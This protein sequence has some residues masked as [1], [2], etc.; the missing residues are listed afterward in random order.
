MSDWLVSLNDL[1]QCVPDDVLVLPAHNSPFK[2]LHARIDQLISG[3]HRGLAHLVERLAKPRRAVDLFGS[4]FTRPIT[5]ELLG[6][7]TG[8]T[9]AHLNYLWKIGNIIRELD[10]QGVYWWRR[11]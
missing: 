2:G 9:M 5:G 3:H 4:L 7:A 11:R 8:E 10:N 6:M 1:K